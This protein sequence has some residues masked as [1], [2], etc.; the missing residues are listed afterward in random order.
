MDLLTQAAS[1][2]PSTVQPS[3]ELELLERSLREVM[4]MLDRVLAYVRD[5]LAGKQK[6]DRAVGRYLMD[7]FGSSTDDLEKSGF[8]TSMQVN[9]ILLRLECLALISLCV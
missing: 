7:T 8:N 9:T 2:T 3:T 4:D 5:V 6:G 1:A